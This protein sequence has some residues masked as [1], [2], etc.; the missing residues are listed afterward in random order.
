MRDEFS[1]PVTKEEKIEHTLHLYIDGGLT[2]RQMW[3]RLTKLA[4]GSAAA[5]AML[6]DHGLAQV[7]PSVC[8][9]GTRVAEND[10]SIVWEDITYPGEVGSLFGLLARP[11]DQAGPQPAVIVI[12]ENRGLVEHIR[13]VTRRVAKAGFV[14]L[15]IDLLSR[16]G[17]TRM[18]AD[19]TARGA[20]Y[21]RTDIGQRYN[22]IHLTMEWLQRQPFVV[23]DRIGAV[24]FCAGG[25]NILHGVMNGMN[26][27][28]AVPFYGSLPALPLPPVEN[29]TTPTLAIYSETDRNQANRIGELAGHMVNARVTFGIQL[30]KGTGHGFH[31]D[32][33][34]IYNAAAACDA[35]SKTIAFFNAHLR[36]PRA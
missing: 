16:Q 23:W 15:G 4:G 1:T 2:R 35:W 29:I 24:G 3:S 8:P 11:K 10:P 25:G 6:E 32:T 7:Q 12:H 5:M 17:G 28:A 14:A 13:D 20:A 19:D 27:Q 22:D 30:Y 31:N 34:A 9:D 18:F 26:L 36:A 21:G 33:G